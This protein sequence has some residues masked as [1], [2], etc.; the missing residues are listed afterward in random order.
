MD[1]RDKMPELLSAEH[2]WRFE[3]VYQSDDETAEEGELE[4]IKAAKAAKKNQKGGADRE[5]SVDEDG[6]MNQ[7]VDELSDASVD[8]PENEQ[9]QKPLVR[10]RPEYRTKEVCVLRSPDNDH[11]LRLPCCLGE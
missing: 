8:P 10:H 6:Q 1:H 3:T 7:E 2:N 5:G 4:D 11:Y 9:G